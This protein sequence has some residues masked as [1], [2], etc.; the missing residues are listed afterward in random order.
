MTRHPIVIVLG[1]AGGC[2]AST[3]ACG[4]ALAWA[5]AGRPP[6]LLEL[7]LERGDLAGELGVVPERGL[8]DL[9]PVAGELAPDHLRQAAFPHASGMAVVLASGRPGAGAGWGGPALARLMRVAAEQRPCVVDA[10]PT[11]PPPAVLAEATTVLL[12]APRTIGGARRARRLAGACAGTP[13]R[14]VAAPPRGVP[15]QELSPRGLGLAAGMEVC[16]SLPCAERD[17]A[18]L[19]GGRWPRRRRAPL[20][21]A[22]A[23]LA[24][25]AR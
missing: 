9:V 17:A 7:D 15:E 14:L 4:L 16:A 10:G 25:A 11:V 8:G 19:A 1:A 23:A 24:E 2:G 13:T 5:R 22:A 3:L 6:Y 12:V 18:D 21:D 20:G